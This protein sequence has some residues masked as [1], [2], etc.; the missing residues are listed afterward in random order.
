MPIAKVNGVQLN[1]VQ[2]DDGQEDGPREDL[3]MVHGLATNLAFWYFQYAPRVADRFRVTLFDLRGHGRSS[4]PEGGYCPAVM[5]QDLA[6]L[7]DHIGIRKAHFL[8]HSY[9]GVVT[10]NF[11]AAQPERV[12]SLVLCDS[13]ISAVRHVETQR[14]WQY[15]QSIQPILDRHGLDLDTS[16]PYFGYK[17]LTRVA[18]FQAR[19]L[20]V[21]P[22]M[23]E[24]VSP[25]MGRAGSRTAA[26]WLHLMSTTSAADEMMGHDSLTLDK[27]RSFRFPI[28]ALYGD[29]SQA[30]LTGSELLAVWPH[31]E[32]R[33][34]RDAGHF[35]PTS[36]PDEVLSGCE[37]FWGGEFA[38]HT[39]RQRVGEPTQR[40]FRSDRIFSA[41]GG[42]YFTTRE[43]NR[44]GPFEGHEEARAELASF[45]LSVQG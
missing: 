41:P 3:I 39:H 22:E 27:L 37:R 15:G 34:V 35:F 20:P 33:R 40:Y 23:S 28:L 18:E 45:M 11:A 6:G 25:L 24:V 42:W 32:F 1:Y 2:L 14:E 4:M 16:D 19:G 12:Q 8:A 13:H 5:A 7:M 26:Q 17:L 31:A 43:R 36:R 44:V 38:Q 21:P 9:G 29:H 10:M 30:R